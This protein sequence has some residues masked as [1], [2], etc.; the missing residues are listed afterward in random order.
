VALGAAPGAIYG[1]LVAAV[2]LGVYGRWD[3]VPTFAVASVLVGAVAGLLGGV[4]SALWPRQEG[5]QVAV[6]S[7]GEARLRTVELGRDHGSK[8]EVLRGLS[9]G[10]EL[11]ANPADDLRDG[12]RVEARRAAGAP[13]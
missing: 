9:A 1:G 6:V 7:G 11:A 3:Q 10:D 2:H 5:P 12:S 13:R 8:V 4:V